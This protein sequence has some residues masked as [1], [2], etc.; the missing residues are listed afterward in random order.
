MV[1]Q[2]YARGAGDKKMGGLGILSSS[3][4]SPKVCVWRLL[5]VRVFS[6]DNI[7]ARKF[8]LVDHLMPTLKSGSTN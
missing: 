2:R 5:C 1:P 7:A 8:M 3:K 6:Y 4:E